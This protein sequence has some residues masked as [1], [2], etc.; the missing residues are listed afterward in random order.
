VAALTVVGLVL[1]LSSSAA[2]A[3]TAPPAGLDRFVGLNSSLV[4]RGDAQTQLGTVAAAGVH[5]VRESVMWDEVQPTPTTWNWSNVDRLLA[6]AGRTGTDVLVVLTHSPSWATSV[7]GVVDAPPRNAADYVRFVQAFVARYGATG[8]FWAANP[9]LVHSLAAVELWNE[10]WGFWDWEPGPDPAAYAAMAEASADAIRSI[11]ATLPILVPGDLLQVRRDGA[12][13]SW[14]GDVLRARPRLAGLVSAWSVHPYTDPRTQGPYVDHADRRWDYSVV[15]L[16]RDEVRAAGSSAPLWITEVG[17]HT[18]TTGGGVSEAQQATFTR[19]AI[20]RAATEWSSF[21]SRVYLYAYGLDGTNGADPEQRY[22]LQHPDGSPKPAWTELVS[23]LAASAAAPVAPAA[24]ATPVVTAPVVTT[25]APVVTAPVVTAPAPVAPPAATAATTGPAPAPTAAAHPELSVASSPLPA[26]AEPGR[27]GHNGDGYWML[28]KAGE[29]SA[30]GA[31]AW[32]G[33]AATGRTPAVDLAAAPDGAGYWVVDAT[34]RV[35]A[36]GSSRFLGGTPGLNAGETVTSISAT[37]SGLGYW[38]FTSK[39]RVAAYGDAPFLGDLGAVRLNAPV[40]D[41][42]ATPSGAGYY[43]V[44]A[45]GGIF[46]FGDALFAGSTGNLRLNAPV[47]SLV[48][49]PDGFGYW[50]V[51]SDGG[52]FAFDSPFYGSMGGTRLNRPVTGM[53]GGGDGYLMVGEDGGIFTFAGA[54]FFGSLGDRPPAAPITSVA[55]RP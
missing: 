28:T 31:A 21:V 41:S 51:A 45:D 50:L 17:W 8:S 23:L 12:I 26:V 5:H 36:F 52:I 22:M 54:P 16:I 43:L 2:S 24:P 30:F 29:V 9:T 49:D 46:T 42:A 20:V 47:E 37:P 35:F 11:D 25:P 32:F 4:W 15:T 19:D 10:P 14:V 3:A 33:N 18:A 6:G 48:P 27:A 39:G 7:T 55:V 44:G 13:Q 53:V 38:L 1:T 40:L 34:G